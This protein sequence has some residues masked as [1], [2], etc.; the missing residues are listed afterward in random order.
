MTKNCLACGGELVGPVP[1]TVAYRA[2]PGV[3]LVNVPVWTCSEC[4]EEEVGLPRLNELQRLL[5]QL[6]A[7]RPGRLAPAEIRFLRKHLGWNGR[8]F[9]AAFDVAPETVSRWEDGERNMGPTAERLLR[10]CATRL[11]PLTDFAELT[12]LLHAP[13]EEDGRDEPI[14]VELG[15]D[16]AWSEAA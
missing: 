1:Q 2:L 9:A 3:E 16:P 11:E 15:P 7:R 8:T 13:S 6:V 10:L 12:P 14:R 4:G 5:A